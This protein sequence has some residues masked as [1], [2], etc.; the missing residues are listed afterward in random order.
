VVVVDLTVQALLRM[1][2]MADQAAEVLIE[3][4]RSR[5]AL[6]ISHLKQEHQEPTDMV[7]MAAMV[8]MSEIVM[9]AA[10]AAVGPAAQV[11]MQWVF[12]QPEMEVTARH[13]I[14]LV[15]V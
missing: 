15:R 8:V 5:G 11:Q 13:P 2:Q 10:V 7:M 14:S 3:S 9:M 1:A 6:E 12:L 4:T